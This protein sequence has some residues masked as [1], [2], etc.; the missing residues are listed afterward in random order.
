[1]SCVR[2]T[3]LFRR[4]MT[5]LLTAAL[6]LALLAPA[7]ASAAESDLRKRGVKLGEWKL[8][9][10]LFVEGRYDSNVFRDSDN[11]L[12]DG[13]TESPVSSGILNIRPGVAVANTNTRTVAFRLGALADF[14]QYLSGNDAAQEQ[15]GF[16][17]T[18]TLNAAFFP[19]NTFTFS[20]F[21][22][23]K[24]ALN[25]PNRALPQNLN[26]IENQGGIAFSIRPGGTP[27]RKPLSFTLG[28]TNELR[29]FGDDFNAGDLMAHRGSFRALWLFFPKT[30]LV[31]NASVARSA[32]LEEDNTTGSDSTPVRATVGVDGLITRKVAVVANVGFGA[33]MHD[34][35]DAFTGFVGGASVVY[36]P[37][38]TLSLTAG[39]RRDFVNSTVGNYYTNTEGRF[40]LNAQFLRRFDASAGVSY[41][42][43]DFG[44]EDK[45]G[46][47]VDRKDNVLG[48]SA[49]IQVHILRFVGVTVGYS[50]EDVDSNSDLED[51]DRNQVYG[52]VNLRY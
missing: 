4:G 18:A 29:F 37:L 30:A 3:R 28:Y 15:G 44:N 1:M 13:S 14:K 35:G 32:Y 31:V 41:G 9:P 50:F 23:F 51:Y 11:T 39:F 20:V 16:G 8:F 34:D 17:A 49:A 21:D 12:P 27:K 47:A 40:T 48:A 38:N 25:S 7:T 22:T 5:G 45:R 42:V 36:A 52:S 6:S 26:Y 19:R 24:R 33:S 10:R 46:N 43:A 2:R